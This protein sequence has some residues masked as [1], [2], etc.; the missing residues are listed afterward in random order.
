MLYYVLAFILGFLVKA[1][2]WLD[3]DRKS[4]NPIKFLLAVAY[5]AIIG[6]LIATASFSTLFLG[7]LVAQAFARKIDTHAH[8]LGAAVSIFSLFFFGFPQ[9]Q[10]V[11]FLLFFFLAYIDELNFPKQFKWVSEWRI[12]LKIGAAIFLIFGRWDYILAILLFDGGYLLFN[13]IA[14]RLLNN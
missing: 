2:D 8:I 11:G 6:Y 10:L 13:Q 5:G 12:L 9:V 4:K 14:K 3:D 7:A 1:V